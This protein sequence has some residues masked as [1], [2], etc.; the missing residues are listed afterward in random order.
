[1]Q[2]NDR[3]GALA[4]M[5]LALLTLFTLAMGISAAPAFRFAL[6]QGD[7]MVRMVGW[8]VDVRVCLH[9][10]VSSCLLHAYPPAQLPTH[11]RIGLA[12]CAGPGDRVGIQLSRGGRD[13]VV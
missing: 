4:N 10:I 1:M 2:S 11:A 6:S 9:D 7:N 3:S 12:S 13:C 8:C 5:T